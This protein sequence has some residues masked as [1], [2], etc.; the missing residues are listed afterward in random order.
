[1][2]QWHEFE[3]KC[4][5]PRPHHPILRQSRPIC[6]VQFI[7]GAGSLHDRHAAQKAEQVCRREDGLIN[8]YSRNDGGVGILEIDPL[9]QELEPDCSS[10]SE[11]SLESPQSASHNQ[12]AEFEPKY[13]HRTV[14]SS[15]F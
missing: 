5:Y 2:F 11:N 3:I 13:L 9:L 7:L 8:Q 14:S 15:R 1:M 6:T 4:L 10:R 12:G